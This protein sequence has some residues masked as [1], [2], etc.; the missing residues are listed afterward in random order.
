MTIILNNC[1]IVAQDTPNN[2]VND[3]NAKNAY[4]G[5]SFKFN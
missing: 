1:K 3:I 4:F 5:N 2:L